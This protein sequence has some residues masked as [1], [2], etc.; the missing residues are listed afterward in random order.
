[1]ARTVCLLLLGLLVVATPLMSN[2]LDAVTTAASASPASSACNPR[3]N[4]AAGERCDSRSRT[5]VCNAPTYAPCTTGCAKLSSDAN[6]CGACDNVCTIPGQ[7]CN[8]GVCACASSYNLCNST[9]VPVC[10]KP[11]VA[12]ASDD[13]NCGSCGNKC[14]ALGPNYKCLRGRCTCS[15]PFTSCSA[16][17]RLSLPAVCTN[18]K[19]DAANCGSCGKSCKAGEECVNKK[20]VKPACA[21][22]LLP[23]GGACVNTTS[24]LNNCGGCGKKC[25][26]NSVCDNGACACDAGLET[27]SNDPTGACRVSELFSEQYLDRELW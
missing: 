9:G 22:G 19:T 24:D 25:G 21:A 10:V 27:C 23:C 5:C 11:S 26:A 18:L 6:N 4:T 8:R 12:F 14:S 7:V 2:A 3:C 13:N 16:K 20:C 1:M 17:P 15:S